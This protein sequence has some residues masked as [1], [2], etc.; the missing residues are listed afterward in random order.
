MDILGKSKYREAPLYL[1]RERWDGAVDSD[2]RVS[3]AKR[4][5]G[6]YSSTLPARTKKWKDLY[7]LDFDWILEEC[8]GAGLVELFETHSVGLGVRALT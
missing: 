5:R 3:S 7:G 4:V 8:F 6:E 1:L 2:S